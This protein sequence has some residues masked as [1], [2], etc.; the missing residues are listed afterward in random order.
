MA[1]QIILLVIVFLMCIKDWGKMSVSNCFAPMYTI[2][3]NV[4]IDALT[5]THEQTAIQVQLQYNENQRM[6]FPPILTQVCRKN[7]ALLFCCVVDKSGRSGGGFPISGGE[8]TKSRY[9]YRQF[10]QNKCPPTKQ[11]HTRPQ[12]HTCKPVVHSRNGMLSWEN[13]FYK[14]L[15]M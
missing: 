12:T 15:K 1:E 10:K 14:T 6:Q 13:T 9:T 8:N 2:H 5:N 4:H 7:P 11:L 3:P